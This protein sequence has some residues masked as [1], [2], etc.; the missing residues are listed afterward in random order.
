MSLLGTCA[1]LRKVTISI[2]MSACSSVCPSTCPHGTGSPRKDFQEILFR[3]F[4]ENLSRN[5]KF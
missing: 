3:V 2:A 1:K 4:F 5:F